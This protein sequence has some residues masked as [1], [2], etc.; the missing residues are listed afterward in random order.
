MKGKKVF[1]SYISC[2]T[3]G[4]KTRLAGLMQTARTEGI[5]SPAVENC[6]SILQQ[7]GAIDNALQQ[8]RSLVKEKS[9]ALA[10]LLGEP[11]AQ[12]GNCAVVRLFERMLPAGT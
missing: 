3:P 10:A 4:R 8:G 2:R 11:E 5:S 7:G 12:S 9:R 6:I 1:R